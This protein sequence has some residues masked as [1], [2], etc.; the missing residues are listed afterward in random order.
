VT[1]L[2]SKQPPEKPELWVFWMRSHDFVG[3]AIAS[4][5]DGLY[6]HTGLM[7]YNP[8]GVATCYEAI[9]AKGSIVKVDARQ[10]FKEFL[11][12]S[13]K[14]QMCLVPITWA[15]D[16]Q[17][18]T[19]LR[20]AESCVKDV[21]YGRWQLL[22][23]LGAQRWGFPIRGSTTKQVCSELVARALGGGDVESACPCICDLRDSRHN[24]YDL[25]NPDSAFRQMM[26]IVAGYGNYTNNP[27]IMLH[28]DF[29]WS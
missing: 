20:Y 6:S 15:T 9:F 22:A 13:A 8:D 21:A 19:A 7:V 17:I 23:M 28:P 3:N 26:A 29:Q 5:T 18:A 14:N 2:F 24:R 11:A 25:V 12:E 16:T 4:V 10:R 27:P 1:A